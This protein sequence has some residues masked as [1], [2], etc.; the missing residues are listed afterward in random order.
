METVADAFRANERLLWGLG[1]RMT[2]LASDADEL[3]QE[4]FLRALEH[5][6]PDDGRPL[7][8]WLVRVC[9][10]L[11]RDR[12]RARRRRVRNAAWLP[13]PVPSERFGPASPDGPASSAPD[14]ASFAHDS[15]EAR[16][17][18]AETVGLAFLLALEALTP[19]QRAVLL[20]RDVFDL[21]A[22][23]VAEALGSTPG[24]VRVAHHKARR[25]LVGHT[26]GGTPTSAATLE[27][28]TGFLGALAT[29]DAAAA[30][31]LLAPGV[32]L[33]SDGGGVYSAAKV[34]VCGAEKVVRFLLHLAGGS[35]ES[36]WEIR[37]INGAPMV[38]IE[39]D[40]P[41]PK[42]APRFVV[43]ITLGTSGE[44]VAIHWVLD[45]AKLGEIAPI[46]R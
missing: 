35:G 3:V 30:L 31:S 6:V 40:A 36:R 26:P 43:G 25:A 7:R 42:Q 39:L 38:V 11:A 44:I 29:G 19:T 21:G 8:P 28:L 20:L 4:T 18:R 1:Y 17:D 46:A 24:A 23:E 10:N 27:A 14:S 34:P 32:V 37:S 9:A 45:P 15:A 12:L 13:S 33:R 22:D 16:Y 2:G 41:L 5:P